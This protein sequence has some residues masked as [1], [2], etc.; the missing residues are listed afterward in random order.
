MA[1]LVIAFCPNLV[2]LLLARSFVGIGAALSVSVP[3]S[4]CVPIG[5]KLGMGRWMS[6][7][8]TMSSLGIIIAPLVSGVVPDH[9]GIDLVFYVADVACLLDTPLCWC[10]VRGGRSAMELDSNFAKSWPTTTTNP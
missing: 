9:L 5:K 10:Y 3:L 8:N 4:H 7:F 6:I 2:T 1:L